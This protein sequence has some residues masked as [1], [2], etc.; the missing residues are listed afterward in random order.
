V[1]KRNK[2][3]ASPDLI[4]EFQRIVRRY[5]RAGE[6]TIELPTE[7]LVS[8]AEALKYVRRPGRPPTRGRTKV[9]EAVTFQLAR[10]RIPAEGFERVAREMQRQFPK[11]APKTIKRRL[12]R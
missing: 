3:E 9:A 8:I 4:E 10:G 7:M 5:Q 1:T 11:L 2:L 6:K 12:G